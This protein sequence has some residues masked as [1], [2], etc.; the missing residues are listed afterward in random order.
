MSEA[1]KTSSS[2]KTNK[3]GSFNGFFNP[4]ITNEIKKAVLALPLYEAAFNS[5]ISELVDMGFKLSFRE[6]KSGT[7]YTV[8]AFDLR[9][10]SNSK[11]YVLSVKHSG[12]NTAVGLI[13]YLIVEVYGGDGW[14]PWIGGDVDLDW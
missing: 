6:D 14:Q 1:K 3:N 12:I 10:N 5:Y 13:W 4:N 7:H 11:G 2:Q 8:T 9:E